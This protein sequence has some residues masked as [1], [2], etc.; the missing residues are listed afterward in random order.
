MTEQTEQTERIEQAEQAGERIGRYRL[1]SEIG[2]GAMGIVYRGEDEALGR[3]VAIKTIL[4]SMD[5]EEQAGYLARFRQEA[6]ALG[7]LNHPNIITVYE[8]GDE[9]GVAY[10]AMEYLEGRELRDMIAKKQLDLTTIVEIAAQVAE[11]LAFAHARGIVHRDVKPGN[12]MVVGG[13]RV[14]IMDFGIA[15]VRKSD[16]KTN[17]GLLLG[18]PKYMAP[19]QVIGRPVDNRSDIFSL[20][21]VLY[22]MIAGSPPFHA[23]DIAA[24]MYQVCNNKPPP[25]SARNLGVPRALDLIVARAMEKEPEAR[26]Q[27]AAAMAADLRACL[28]EIASGAMP[29]EPV[30]TAAAVDETLAAAAPAPAP[31]PAGIAGLHL[32]TRFD[33]A[34]ALAR[35][36]EPRGEDRRLMAPAT[37]PTPIV[38]RWLGDGSLMAALAMIAAAAAVAWY[39]AY[40]S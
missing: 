36:A 18:S 6:K 2:R 21:V 13:N 8:F 12:V 26:Y 23:D 37:G 9:G 1:V 11:G 24:I 28:P 5:A 7:G 4:A 29:G 33:S 27:D 35:L 30:A 22:E 25:P 17:T 3:S 34:A 10:L 40:L 20:G 14:K 39:V 16:V 38:R 19:E 31:A 32:A 15:R